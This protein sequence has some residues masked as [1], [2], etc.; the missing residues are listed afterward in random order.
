MADFNYDMFSL[1]NTA[2]EKLREVSQEGAVPTGIGAKPADEQEPMDKGFYESMYEAIM[3][4]FDKAE[5]ADRVLT[6]KEIDKDRTKEEVLREFDA[7]DRL[8]VE[9]TETPSLD[10]FD[11]ID[12][13]TREEMTDAQAKNLR[14]VA[15]TEFGQ[16]LGGGLKDVTD[17]EE[18]KLT[19]EE[20]LYELAEDIDPGTIDTGELDADGVQPTDGKGLMSPRLD[21][22]GETPEKPRIGD[23][24]FSPIEESIK[25]KTNK[26][27]LDIGQK[28]E[29]DHGSVPKPTND[30]AEKDIP[31]AQRSKDVG[32][33]HKVKSSEEASG[34]IHGIKF[35][36][37]DGTYI[38]LTEAQKVEILNKDMAA[39]LA[40]ARNGYDGK[41]GW[42]AK[43]KK[44]GIT[45]DELDYKYQNALTSLAYNVGGAKAG[46][47][48]TKVLQ[49]AKD[50]NVKEF[51]KQMRRKDS[52]K[53]TAGMDNRVAK[54]LY[55]AG[56][57]S[58][59]DDVSSVLPLADATVSGVP[60][61]GD[62]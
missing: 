54:E 6:A 29:T 13:D 36:N 41:E 20:P 32:F 46:T 50:G 62:A 23:V 58:G 56:I 34:E 37:E 4:Y 44:L 17:T 40:L 60:Q 55:Y 7:L 12:V 57:I 21:I 3:S 49:A 14:E 42:D 30:T 24:N 51:A 8:M 5:D 45:W 33:G 22:K 38:K 31:E 18:G 1:G 15:T 47:G 19:N 39:E 59:L 35:K 16:P 52:G 61:S 25:E 53:N 28:A 48:W 10:Y 27:Y 26:F 9:D 2:K 11:E 43:L